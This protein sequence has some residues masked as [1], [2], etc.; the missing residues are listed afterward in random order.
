[1]STLNTTHPSGRPKSAGK[2][3]MRRVPLALFGLIRRATD[4]K[5]SW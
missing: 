3:E 4:R 2:G 1:M 5:K